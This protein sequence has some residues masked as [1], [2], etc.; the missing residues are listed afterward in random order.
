[1]SIV[2]ARRTAVIV[3]TIAAIGP[4]MACTAR[5]LKIEFD[6]MT[7]TAYPVSQ[8]VSGTT[9]SLASIYDPFWR[10]V[11]VDQDTTNIAP[12][13][14]PFDPA[15][16]NQYDFITEAELDTVEAAN[17]TLPIGSQSCGSGCRNYH[18]YGIVV[19]HF[20]E[21][22][23]GVRWT[24]VL[25][26]MWPTD[27]RSFAMFYKHNTVQT[28]AGKYLRS[29]A[30]E[31][32]HAHNLHHSDGDGSTTIMNQTGVVGTPIR[33]RSRPA[34]SPTWNRT[35]GPASV[36]AWRPGGASTPRIRITAGQRWGAHETA[37]QIDFHP[38]RRFRARH[39]RRRLA[40]RSVGH[41]GSVQVFVRS[42]RAR[43][44]DVDG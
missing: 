26:I 35:P 39:T 3:L 7:G 21:D 43:L 20:Y 41:P 32:G 12:L 2:T 34:A 18:L 13:T 6:R 24:G 25:G 22:P 42:R 10:T 8:T 38:R 15:D 31:I 29:A 5:H 40:G 33:T 17:R 9:F 1:M 11:V 30:H 27:T 36:R 44:R 16:P 23:M 28:D 37:Q 4:G 19:D 14:G